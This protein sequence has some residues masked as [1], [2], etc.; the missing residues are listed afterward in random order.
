MPDDFFNQ[1]YQGPRYAAG[2]DIDRITT[3]RPVNFGRKPKNEWPIIIGVIVICLLIFVVISHREKEAASAE[4]TEPLTGE[5]SMELVDL[6]WSSDQ[7]KVTVKSR[8]TNNTNKSI[9]N[10]ELTYTVTDEDGKQIGESFKTIK[11]TIVT[12]N[13]YEDTEIIEIDE[14]PQGR[15]TAHLSGQYQ[16][17]R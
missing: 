1:K 12:G 6:F 13:Q 7:T 9:F 17:A 16:R 14:L 3:G 8:I 4:D 10:I 15:I 5:V 2:S 11:E